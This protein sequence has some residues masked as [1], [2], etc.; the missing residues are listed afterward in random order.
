MK[1][2][3]KILLL[4]SLFHDIGK[5][6]QR[7]GVYTRT[8]HPVLGKQFVENFNDE[9]KKI[10]DDNEDAV[11]QF[12]SI[13]LN[14]HSKNAAD[15]TAFCRMADHLSASE[16]V[17]FDKED[18]WQEKWSH[19]YMTS[20]F[21]KIFLNDPNHE[22]RKI[23]Y[24]DQKLLTKKN[25][26][27]LIPQFET[28]KDLKDSNI[29]YSISIFESFQ[30]DV[31]AVLS[32][33]QSD[34]DFNTIVNLLLIVF[35]KYMWC[36]PDFTGSENT[37]ISLFNHSKDVA[38]IA[39]AIYKSNE[40]GS[41]LNLIIG[42]I[43]GIQKYIF[44][45]AYKKPAKILRGRS[46][47]VQ[48]LTRQFASIILEKLGLTDASLIMLAGGKFYIIAQNSKDFQEKFEEAKDDIEQILVE[49]FNYQLSFSSIS[50]LFNYEYL[51]N[52]SITF[53]DII[54]EASY[55]LLLKRNQQFEN[56]LF[57]KGDF[58]ENKFIL[59]DKY[60]EPDEGA[61]SNKIKCAVTGIPIREGRRAEINGEQVDK[62]VWNEY[63][64]GELAPRSNVVIELTNNYS[65]V[66]NVLPIN[67]FKPKQNTRKI[68]LNPDLQVLLHKVNLQKDIL[69]NTQIIEIANYTSKDAKNDYFVM[70]FEEMEKLNNGA[71]VMTLI[72]GDVDNLGLIMSSGLVGNK[73]DIN[74]SSAPEDLTG[75][76]RTT[77]LSN[78]LKY[79]FSFSLNGFLKDW[80]AGVILDDEEKE[81]IPNKETDEFKQHIRD[82]KVYT[83]FAGGDDLMLICPQSSS[84]KLV[85][86]LNNTFNKFVCDNPEVH[87]SYSLTNFKHNTPIRIVAEMAEENQKNIKT[88][89]KAKDLIDKNGNIIKKL[90]IRIDDECDIFYSNKDKSGMRIFNTN[91][92][93]ELLNNNLMYRDNL[94]KWEKDEDNKVSQGILRNLLFFSK[95]MKDFIT[96][97]DT[98][99]LIWHPRLTYLINRLLKD[100]HGDYQDAE[101]RNFFEDTLRINKKDS[102]NALILEQI[103]HPVVCEAIY[104]TRKNKGE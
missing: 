30:N 33:Y 62:Q 42:D 98:R 44:N 101:V 57:N 39:H 27:I 41:D 85:S 76:S 35:E 55:K 29:G 17:G 28:E 12:K 100:R 99:L 96:H 52:K 54:D 1:N 82:R 3:E 59:N 15:L 83:V 104:G 81:K 34:E 5:F 63:K 78:H 87:I 79:F 94:I 70:D 77:T 68:L 75:M 21:S 32:F 16:R 24:Y 50:H 51:K 73:D 45:V 19:K 91:V 65:E 103:L 64:I 95:I 56:I 69:R 67:K 38:G 31:K 7:C 48:I 60:I 92:K 40:G 22:S 20:L 74:E 13:I 97:N 8:P 46:T 71:E 4:G 43:P 66:L 26:D 14:H 18:S 61:D 86:S 53:G 84:L 58:E 11:E 89:F 9:F 37:D 6:E 25:Y 47:Y 102:I 72:K 10:L 2:D 36:I 93:I 88:E 49:N 90:V 80:E 23:K